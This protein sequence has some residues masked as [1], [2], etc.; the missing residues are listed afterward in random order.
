MRTPSLASSSIWGVLIS[1]PN[2]PQSENAMSS[3]T[4]KRTFGRAARASAVWPQAKQNK[5]NTMVRLRTDIVI[6]ICFSLLFHLPNENLGHVFRYQQ[7]H[8]T[9]FEPSPVV[10]TGPS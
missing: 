6:T 1:P 5:N 4:I 9:L 8:R 3:V 2:A 7:D 10:T